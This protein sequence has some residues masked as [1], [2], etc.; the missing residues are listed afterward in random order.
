MLQT[1]ST[2]FY[3]VSGEEVTAVSESVGAPSLLQ[4]ILIVWLTGVLTVSLRVAFGMLATARL[5][6]QSTKLTAGSIHEHVHSSLKLL[7]MKTSVQVALSSSAAVPFL[8]GIVQPII[9]LPATAPNWSTPE[10]R[11]VLLHE[12]AHVKRRDIIWQMVGVIAGT[13]H[14][15]NPLV[16]FAQKRLIVEA[17]QACDD[18]VLCTGADAHT[19]AEHLLEIAR[20]AGNLPW[21][22]PARVAMAHRTRLEGRLMSI[23][24]NRRR[25]TVLKRRMTTLAAAVTVLF[26]LP[27]AGVQLSAAGSSTMTD[28]SLSNFEASS[29]ASG[30]SES[31]EK[32]ESDAKTEDLPGPDDFVAV[33][34]VPKMLVCDPAVYPDSAEKAG[35][36]GDVWIQALVDT[37]GKVRDCRV[38]TS[39]GHKALDRAAL[40]AACACIYT[41]AMKDDKPVAVW[42]TYKTSFKLGDKKSESKD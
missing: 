15:F 42:I 17:E 33:T 39:S 6:R 27:I 35:L 16:W 19:Y 4:W 5:V 7:D 13:T 24:Q 29:A 3:A 2:A 28:M 11:M 36:E 14:W 18:C 25:V 41:P 34:T 21:F 37:Q 20:S 32:K 23:L 40:K 1:T 9:I 22:A 38:K 26:V 31:D 30:D 10:L 8:W 12:L